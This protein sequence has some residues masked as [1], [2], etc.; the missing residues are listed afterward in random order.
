MKNIM[1]NKQDQET[2]EPE[3]PSKSGNKLAKLL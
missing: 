1:L 3:N 2:E